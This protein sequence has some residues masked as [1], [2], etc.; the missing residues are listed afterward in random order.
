MVK[1]WPEKWGYVLIQYQQGKMT[2]RKVEISREE[3]Q[4]ILTALKM[5]LSV[6]QS[7]LK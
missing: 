2:C 7:V 4:F 1:I 6:K 5:L 3:A